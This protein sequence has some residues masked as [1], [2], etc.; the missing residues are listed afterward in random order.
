MSFEQQIQ[1]WV[2]IDNQMKILNEKIHELREKKQ[3]LGENINLHVQNN[4]LTNATIQISD[5]KLKF[6]SSRITPPLTFKY[7]E[8]SLGEIIKNPVQVKQIIDYLKEK[9]DIKTIQEI[10]R[11]TNN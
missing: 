11:F 4:N 6:V 5:G 1:Q 9:R 8:K 7:L 10:K 2:S 3:K